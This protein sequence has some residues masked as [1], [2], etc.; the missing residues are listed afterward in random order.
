[1]K[2]R[3]YL[4]KKVGFFGIIGNIFLFIIKIIIGL[5]SNSRAMIADSF[6][7]AGDIF[8]SFMTWLGSRISSVPNDDDHNFG[9]GK[10]EYIFSLLIGV[11]MIIV[12]IKL[13]YDSILSVIN[14]S[15]ITYSIFLII[16][17]VVTIITKIG[18]YIYSSYI[19]KKTE[20]ML[21][22]SNMLDHRNDIIVTSFTL[23][24]IILSKYCIFWFDGIVGIGIS[25]WIFFVG[26]KIFK[27]SYDVL[28]DTSMDIESK[29]KIHDILKEYNDIKRVGQIYSI[30]IGYNYIVV[31]TIYVDGRM[32]TATSH[33]IA[34]EI[35]GKIRKDI[36]RID[37]VIV[38]IEP[39]IQK[40]NK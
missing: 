36:T 17:A 9:H 34:D 28:M 16:V 22:K 35:E 1:M 12:A 7:S 29:K 6:N 37:D 30:P 38:H 4:A 14:Q 18:L 24:A 33:K 8:A 40:K 10:A 2:E 20:N 3:G 23:I 32:H 5:I 39:N 27:E 26:I 21:V 19:Y 31:L 15:I 25:I 11:S 13:L